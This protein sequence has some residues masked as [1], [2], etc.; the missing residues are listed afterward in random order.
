MAVLNPDHAA[1]V[2]GKDRGLVYK[3]GQQGPLPPPFPLLSIPCA[4]GTRLVGRPASGAAGG[5]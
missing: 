3:E 2:L 1:H 4:P 5:E